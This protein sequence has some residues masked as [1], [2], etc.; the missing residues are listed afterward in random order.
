MSKKNSCVERLISIKK[1]FKKNNISIKTVNKNNICINLQDIVIQGEIKERTPSSYEIVIN[2]PF[3]GLSS[4]TFMS[5]GVDASYMEEYGDYCMAQDLYDLYGVG[6]FLSE[7]MKDLQ[8]KWQD[9]LECIE[10]YIEAGSMAE[11]ED[12]RDELLEKFFDDN[13]PE[14]IQY[15]YTEEIISIIEGK[16]SLT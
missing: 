2:K 6:K 12:I 14:N 16:V 9:V 3:K 13:F 1:F 8:S 10:M 4:N 11:P 5:V 15:I 7:N